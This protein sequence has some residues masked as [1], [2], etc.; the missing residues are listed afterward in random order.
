M[1]VPVITLAGDQYVSRMSTAVLNGAGLKEWVAVDEDNYVALAV[2]QSGHLNQL[3]M[4]RA[5]WRQVVQSSPLGDAAGLM[6]ELEKTFSTMCEHAA[7]HVTA[8]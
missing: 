2:A 8:G 5:H 3:R 4:N 6:H 1:G 7:M